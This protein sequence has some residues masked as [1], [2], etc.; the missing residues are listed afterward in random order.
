MME[1]IFDE[2][3]FDFIAYLDG[4]KLASVSSRTGSTDTYQE[5]TYK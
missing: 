3:S 1:A 5:F 4:T 2:P